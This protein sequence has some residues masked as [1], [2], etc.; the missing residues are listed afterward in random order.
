MYS[1]H[2]TKLLVIINNYITIILLDDQFIIQKTSIT[3]GL[4]ALDTV[5]SVGTE[6]VFELCLPDGVEFV[7]EL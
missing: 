4:S 5:R 3:L 6:L 1:V 2:T 7:S